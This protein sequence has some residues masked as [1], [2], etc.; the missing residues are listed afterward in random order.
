MI[1]DIIQIVVSGSG[2]N[3]QD[4]AGYALDYL[5]AIVTILGVAGPVIGYLSSRALIAERVRTTVKE[6]IQQF[7]SK[8]YREMSRP[9]IQANLK[10]LQYGTR[11]TRAFEMQLRFRAQFSSSAPDFR[12]ADAVQ[13]FVSNVIDGLQKIDI[14]PDLDEYLALLEEYKTSDKPGEN[15]SILVACQLEFYN[16]L[17]AIVNV[18]LYLAEEVD[19][20][21]SEEIYRYNQNRAKIREL[22]RRLA[23]LGAQGY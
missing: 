22:R 21:S 12:I 13:V 14:E 23:A 2:D 6:S 19:R 10:A 18:Q 16:F 11:L 7:S 1:E 20:F 4:K 17:D 5:V 9:I 3:S 8:Q 15:A